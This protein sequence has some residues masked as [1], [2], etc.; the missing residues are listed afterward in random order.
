MRR[1]QSKAVSS[2][3]CA[4]LLIGAASCGLRT[5]LEP[6]GDPGETTT[7]TSTS[8]GKTDAAPQNGAVYADAG[9]AATGTPDAS[10]VGLQPTTP[11]AAAP[12]PPTPDAPVATPVDTRPGGANR[13][14]AGVQT[15]LAGSVPTGR[16][17]SVAR[18]DV[19][20]GFG[21]TDAG[22]TTPRGGRDAG[23][24]I[25]TPDL[26]GRVTRDGGFT[27]T[28]TG[29]DAGV[30]GTTGRDGGVTFGG[31]DAGRTTT[32]RADAGRTR[33]GVTGG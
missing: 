24:T 26:G 14:D 19:G 22:G 6:T 7:N 4:A 20:V 13:P 3:F 33:G 2:V 27:G 18:A 17:A 9:A 31:G 1:L 16:D 12:I 11:D 15:D 23:T 10:T 32:G 30:P 21:G 29:T 25:S 5:T 28:P 8:T